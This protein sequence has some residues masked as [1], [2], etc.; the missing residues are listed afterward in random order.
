MKI[1]RI[2]MRVSTDDQDLTRQESIIDDAKA[3]GFHIAGVYR[4]KASG[5]RTD[6][7]ELLRMIS[8]LQSGEVVIAEKIDRIS[9]LPLAEAESLIASIRQKG[10]KLAIPGVVDLSEFAANAD[11]MAKIVIEATQE[12]LLKLALQVA[13]DDYQ[14]RRM[15]QAQGVQLAKEKGKFKGRVANK[16]LHRRIIALRKEGMGIRR[17]A[18]LAGCSESTVKDVWAKYRASL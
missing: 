2:Y 9:R 3:K 12:M 1:A 11:G 17:T 16:Q 15:R 5:V 14:D 10:A 4:E 8:D 18:E 7:P 13:H 6:R